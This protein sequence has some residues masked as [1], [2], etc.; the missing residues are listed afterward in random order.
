[1]Q[2]TDESQL[3]LSPL[4]KWFKIFGVVF[5]LGGI[6][7]LT[8]P[9]VAGIAIELLLGW[10]FFGVGCIQLTAAFSARRHSSF[11]FKFLWAILFTLVG[12]WLLL[13]PAEG[14]QALAFVVGVLFL[15]EAVVK[16]SF[17]WQR[18]N[19]PNIGW[20]LVSGVL[21]FLIAMI[22]LSGWPQQSATFLGILVGINLLING[23]V[24]LLL[25]FRMNTVNISWHEKNDSET[26]HSPEKDLGDK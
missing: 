2:T 23:I 20:I 7:A 8:V 22:L 24:V 4:S 26:A 11:W 13:R 12:L 15:A 14:V 18:R 1:M 10:L 17:S 21:S 16:I 25:G 5:I 19:T 9:A 3:D 6:A